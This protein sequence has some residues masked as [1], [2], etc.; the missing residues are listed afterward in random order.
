ML[1][2]KEITLRPFLFT[3]LKRL[4]K[5]NDDTLLL[6]IYIHTT[7]DIIMELL[8]YGADVKVIS[9]A[10]LQNEMKNRI[11]QMANLYI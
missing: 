10:R 1:T 5:E 6:E 7:N 8:K 11:S 9:P 2:N 4:F 3:N